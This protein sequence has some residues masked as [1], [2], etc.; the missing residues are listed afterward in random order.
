MATRARPQTALAVALLTSLALDGSA[1]DHPPGPRLRVHVAGATSKP[2][3]GTLIAVENDGFTLRTSESPEL[4]HLR[5]DDVTRIEVRRRSGNR[6]QAMSIG[7]FAGAVAG[8]LLTSRGSDGVATRPIG[9]DFNQPGE[10]DLGAAL[11]GGALGLMTGAAVS[12]GEL[13]EAT[14]FERLQVAVV[15]VRGRGAAVRVAWRF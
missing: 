15:P 11:I 2:F 10:V 9:G 8:V 4:L 1:A 3:V 7:L 5:R 6:L 14:T 12:H 13:W